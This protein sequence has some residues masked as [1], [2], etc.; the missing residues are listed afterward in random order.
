MA[1]IRSFKIK[2]YLKTENGVLFHGDNVEVLRTFDKDSINLI[3]TSPPYFDLRK[4][5]GYSWDFEALA[6][7]LLRVTKPGGIVV[8]IVNDKTKDF[9]QSGSSFRQALYF[10]DIGFNL[11]DTLFWIK[12]N[13][14]TIAKDTATYY[15]PATEYMFILSKGRPKTINLLNDRRNITAGNKLGKNSKHRHGTGKEG[16]CNEYGRRT[17]CWTYNTAINK[18]EHP[19]VFPEK[20]ARDLIISWSNKDDIVFDPFAGSGTVPKEAEKLHRKWIG[21]EISE[22]YCGIIKKRLYN[23]EPTFEFNGDE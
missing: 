7:E 1:K 23:T 17:N 6:K 10:Q 21:I 20:L 9:N 4:Y 18:T 15:I 11:Y 8:W 2:P 13:P 12:N 19:A 5:E 14:I 3:V 22:K 16:V